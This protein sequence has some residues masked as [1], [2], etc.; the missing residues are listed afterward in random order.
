MILQ[1]DIKISA[2]Q[3]F[4]IHSFLIGVTWPHE[5]CLLR[6]VDWQCRMGL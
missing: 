1:N 4:H 3:I 2:G 6:G 5:F